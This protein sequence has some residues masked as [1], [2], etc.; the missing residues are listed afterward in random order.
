MSPC[1]LCGAGTKEAGGQLMD[2]LV[3]PTALPPSAL[4]YLWRGKKQVKRHKRTEE[5]ITKRI[6]ISFLKPFN[7]MNFSSALHQSPPKCLA[8]GVS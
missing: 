6:F 7:N 8:Q 3:L 1:D 4:T 2:L 5:I